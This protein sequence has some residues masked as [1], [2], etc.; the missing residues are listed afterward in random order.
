MKQ[1]ANV[2]Q[3]RQLGFTRKVGHTAGARVGIRSAQVLHCHVLVRDRLYDVGSRHEH[4]ARAFYHVDE[5]GNGGR[6]H[7]TTRARPED[8]GNLRHHPRG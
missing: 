6:I 7:G 5:I 1:L 2:L 3:T 4:V 8:R